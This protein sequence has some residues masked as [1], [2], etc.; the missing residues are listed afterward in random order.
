[1]IKFKLTNDQ[2]IYFKIKIY[3]GICNYKLQIYILP[4][5]V[6]FNFLLASM[7]KIL[8]LKLLINN[9]IKTILL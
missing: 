1:M 2:N 7:L 6:I 8:L 4:F 9:I 3:V 5:L